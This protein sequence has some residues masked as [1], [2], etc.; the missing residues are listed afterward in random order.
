MLADRSWERPDTDDVV[1]DFDNLS[2]R[3][4]AP[5]ADDQPSALV[6][7]FWIPCFVEKGPQESGLVLTVEVDEIEL[8]KFALLVLASS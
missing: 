2:D 3:A 4:S 7:E 1:V 5:F 8:G 6:D